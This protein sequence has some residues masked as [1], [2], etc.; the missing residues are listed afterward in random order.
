MRAFGMF[1]CIVGSHVIAEATTIWT[2]GSNFLQRKK[3]N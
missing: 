3:L 1:L 2:S